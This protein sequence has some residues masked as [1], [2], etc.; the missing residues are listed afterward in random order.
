M[1]SGTITERVHMTSGYVW[2]ELYAWHDTNQG[3]AGTGRAGLQAQPFSHVESPETKTRLNSMIHVSGLI[4]S[5]TRIPP[6]YATEEDLLRV[7]TSDHVESVRRLSE[8][9]GGDGGDGLTPFGAGSYEIA[10]LAAGGTI[11]ALEAVLDGTVRNAYALVRPPGHHARP[12]KGMGA[13]LFANIAIAIQWA[14][15]TRAVGRVA[16]VDW[17]VHHGNGTQTIFE[18]DPDTLTISL[19]QE[20][21]F[22]FDSGF[23]EENG[24]G[25]GA[26]ATINI[27]LPAGTGNGGY[28][29]AVREAVVPALE[30]FKPE[31]ILVASGFD[32]SALDPL[33]NQVVTS[34]GYREMTRLLMAAADDLCDGRLVL[35]HEGGYSP[36]YVP[37]CGLAVLEQLSGINTGVD[38]YLEELWARGPASKATEAQLAVIAQ[39]RGLARRL[40]M[41]G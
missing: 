37:F 15:A 30:A 14:R 18:E 7:H 31:V 8:A 13:C 38:D 11:A 6:R 5:L 26:G 40:G 17:D 24:T 25:A 20:Q 19:H 36:I 16:V 27:P 22:P 29:D 9:G 4:D 32:A 34:R 21:L 3:V 39:A 2:H 33:G 41:T 12:E 28:I 23:L 35:S 1:R 10:K